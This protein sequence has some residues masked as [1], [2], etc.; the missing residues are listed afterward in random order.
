MAFLRHYKYHILIAAI[1]LGGVALLEVPVFSAVSN[2]SLI[3]HYWCAAGWTTLQDHKSGEI[4]KFVRQDDV[5]ATG[6]ASAGTRGIEPGEGNP[7]M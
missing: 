2:I 7:G 1:T 4:P 6:R 3:T 5:H